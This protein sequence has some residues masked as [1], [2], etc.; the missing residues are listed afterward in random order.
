MTIESRIKFKFK[1]LIA[2]T[3][4][5]IG[6]IQTEAGQ[7][8]PEQAQQVVKGVILQMPQGRWC[9]SGCDKD[10]VMLSS[11]TNDHKLIASIAIGAGVAGVV[12]WRLCSRSQAAPNIPSTLPFVPSQPPK[13]DIPE[14]PVGELVSLGLTL[15]MLGWLIGRTTRATKMTN[16]QN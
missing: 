1:L 13:L 14:P 15:A 16:S 10:E 9:E 7:I 12:C 6:F 11:P 2:A 8:K 3:I 4:M 5:G